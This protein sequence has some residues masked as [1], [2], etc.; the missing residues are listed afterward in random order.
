MTTIRGKIVNLKKTNFDKKPGHLTKAR[1]R[2]CE[3]SVSS[4]RNVPSTLECTFRLGEA[5]ILQASKP[6]KGRSQRGGASKYF[7]SQQGFADPLPKSRIYKRDVVDFRG[8]V[9][10]MIHASIYDM[11]D[12]LGTY[13]NESVRRTIKAPPL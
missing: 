4:R 2:V 3:I 5:R 10:Q 9:P 1:A 8:D 13:W 12:V 7:F 6:L 11:F